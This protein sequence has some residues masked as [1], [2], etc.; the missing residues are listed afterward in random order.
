[1]I[2]AFKAIVTELFEDADDN[3]SSN[4]VFEAIKKLKE[5]NGYLEIANDDLEKISNALN[6]DNSIDPILKAIT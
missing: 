4:D 5:S 3:K 1:M 2:H 6:V